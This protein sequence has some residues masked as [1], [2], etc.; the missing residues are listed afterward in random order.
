MSSFLSGPT[1]ARGLFAI[2]TEYGKNIGREGGG[3]YRMAWR[4]C[5]LAVRTG[6]HILTFY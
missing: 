1:G 3:A 4:E 6:S 5:W 2:G